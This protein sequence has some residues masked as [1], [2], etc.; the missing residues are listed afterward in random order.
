MYA[1][2][3]VRTRMR[4]NQKVGLL[5]SGLANR[6]DERPGA[7]NALAN[8]ADAGFEVKIFRSKKRRDGA[9]ERAADPREGCPFFFGRI[10]NFSRSSMPYPLMGVLIPSVRMTHHNEAAVLDTTGFLVSSSSSST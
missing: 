3:V 1:P 9:G 10:Y 8:R 7:D 2:H 6:T 5:Q 4:V